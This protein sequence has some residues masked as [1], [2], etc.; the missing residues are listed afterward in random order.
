MTESLLRA[1]ELFIACRL[2]GRS[3]TPSSS[4][5]YELSKAP[6]VVVSAGRGTYPLVVGGNELGFSSRI[7]SAPRSASSCVRYGPDHTVVRSSTRM[8]S[9]G[10]VDG[11]RCAARGIGVGRRLE[12]LPVGVELAE[13]QAP[14]RW[15]R[16]PRLGVP[17]RR[18]GDQHG[19]PA[20][21][22][23]DLVPE[24]ALVE[25]VDLEHLVDA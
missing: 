11:S 21:R 20:R 1:I 16:Q 3:S 13:R 17:V 24:A 23:L 22:L 19:A 14:A 7:T 4:G 9:S 5:P 10:G 25:V 12:R 2:Y 6:S 8:P 15:S 18:A